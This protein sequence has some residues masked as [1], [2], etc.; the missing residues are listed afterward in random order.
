MLEP[1]EAEGYTRE[2]DFWDLEDRAL[3]KEYL[4][5]WIIVKAINS[6]TPR[7]SKNTAPKMSDDE[8]EK[9]EAKESEPDLDLDL[10]PGLALDNRAFWEQRLNL[11]SPSPN[12]LSIIETL[13]L[14]RII[15]DPP[16]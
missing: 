1:A 8:T 5:L 11:P 2:L 10:A 3:I 15:E 4:R 6:A 9:V 14:D 7:S 13:G 16:G 12:V